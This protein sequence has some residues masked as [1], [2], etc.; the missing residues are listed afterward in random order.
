[1]KIPMVILSWHRVDH[2]TLNISASSI[3][4][5]T[6]QHPGDLLGVRYPRAPF[7]SVKTDFVYT[8]FSAV[9]LSKLYPL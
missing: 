2:G 7:I 6:L 4:K 1:M 5:T 9:L 8:L 3:K